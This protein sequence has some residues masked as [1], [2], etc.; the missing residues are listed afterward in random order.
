MIQKVMLI[1]RKHGWRRVCRAVCNV[2]RVH[3]I[4]GGSRH[5]RDALLR[6]GSAD[7]PA[8]VNSMQA[9]CAQSAYCRLS[10]EELFGRSVLF[11]GALDLPQCKKYRV[12]AREEMFQRCGG[13]VVAHSEYRDV[14]RWRSLVQIASAVYAYRIP[15]GP[16]FSFLLR[17]C[18][19]LG[20]HV[21]YDIDDPVFDLATVT[22]NPNLETLS[23]TTRRT[24][25]ADAAS[26]FSAMSKV[27][28]ICVSTNGLATIA[29]RAFPASRV[30]VVPNA[31]DSESLVYAKHARPRSAGSSQRDANMPFNVV[32]ASGSMAHDA[33]FGVCRKGLKD[34]MEQRRDVVL[35]ICGHVDVADICPESR[36]IRYPFLPYSEYLRVIASGDVTLVPLSACQFNEAKSCVRLL[37][38]AIV[39]TP[40]IASSVGEYRELVSRRVCWGVD[41]SSGWHQALNQA[42]EA[43]QERQEMAAR[44]KCYATEMRTVDALWGSLST[45]LSEPLGFVANN[46]R[47]G[48]KLHPAAEYADISLETTAHQGA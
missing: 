30:R 40:V 5:L 15:D 25:A 12:I 48:S 21:I 17:E 31:V 42:I 27:K 1:L 26:F 24:L 38:S 22:S 36:V 10:G 29:R 11:V 39:G 46:L 14:L 13:M 2:V 44:A 7:V 33:D 23:A 18:A 41:G 35:T 20:V 28:D 6:S 34:F 16:E 43:P 47:V 37:D 8:A 32:V 9:A 4:V 19:R 3:G 45:Q